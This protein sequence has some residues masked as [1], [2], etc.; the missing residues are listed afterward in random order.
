MS[1]GSPLS[2][3]NDA[4]GILAPRCP[5]CGWQA[6][7]RPDHSSG[8]EAAKADVIAH[9]AECPGAPIEHFPEPCAVGGH[10]P[11]WCAE[12]MEQWPCSD[13]APSE[14]VEWDRDEV[15]HAAAAYE[16]GLE[17]GLRAGY[18]AGQYMG[19]ANGL[20]AAERAVK[21]VRDV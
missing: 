7:D 14:Q 15:V 9:K 3:E 12:C 5:L 20:A 11:V 16:A 4:L 21:E 17:T 10:G 2:G 19:M 6:V 18:R 13:A 1:A 8:Y